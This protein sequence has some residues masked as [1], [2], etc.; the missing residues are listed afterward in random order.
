MINRIF[1]SF[2]LH[3]FLVIASGCSNKSGRVN[4]QLTAKADQK[5]P[6]LIGVVHSSLWMSLEN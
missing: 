3:A 1:F 6:G 5:N 2:I 4:S